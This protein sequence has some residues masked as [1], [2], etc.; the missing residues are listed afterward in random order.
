[1]PNVKLSRKAKADLKSIALYTERK[2]GRE[3]RNHYILQFDQ[4]FHLLGENP[5]LGQACD[6]ISPGYRQYPQGRHIIFYRPA[7]EGVVEIIRILHKR[8]LPEG[9]LR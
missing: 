1:M 7:T 6:E 2:W 4:C 3:Q 5:D 9:H 8:M